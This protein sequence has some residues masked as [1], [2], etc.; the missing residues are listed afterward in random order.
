MREEQGEALIDPAAAAVRSVPHG[1]PD[2][3]PD[4]VP[5]GIPAGS[6]ELDPAGQ[7]AGAMMV[8]YG[9]DNGVDPLLLLAVAGHETVFG[10]EGVGV[11]GMLGVGAYDDDPN[12]S[13]RNPKFSGI[14]NQIR[15]GAETFA[16]LRA[17]AGSSEHDSIQSQLQAANQAGWATD[18]EWHGGVW[19][20]YEEILRRASSA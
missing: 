2:A 5:V 3:Q 13:T 17:Q 8:R 12:N 18:P 9:H 4:Q 11:N 16:R 19:Q 20:H 15:V 6:A 14:E 7:G 1:D 10:K